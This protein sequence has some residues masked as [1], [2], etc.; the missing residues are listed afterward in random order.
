LNV[1]LLLQF[2]IGLFAAAWSEAALACR[3]QLIF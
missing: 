3:L 1:D 2:I